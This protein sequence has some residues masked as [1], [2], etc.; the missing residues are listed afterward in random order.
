[1]SEEKEEPQ[2]GVFTYTYSARQRE[3]IRAIR[4]KYMPR[5]EDKME[6]L[7]RLDRS[8]TKKGSTVSLTVGI[9]GSLVMG[10]GMSMTM[11][12]PDRWFAPGI[13]IGI[14]G[15]IG[16]GIAYPLYARVTKKERE[17]VAPEILRL[18]EELL[19]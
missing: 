3:E 16:V 9:A 2:S 13:V 18:S 4:K 8:V 12:G 15:M 6:Q 7:R 5:E 14:A 1:M 11:A 17:R 10:T 19:K